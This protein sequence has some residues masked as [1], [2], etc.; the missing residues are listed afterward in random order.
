M[1][2]YHIDYKSNIDYWSDIANFQK[3]FNYLS[4]EKFTLIIEKT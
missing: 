3:I 2:F 1:N 4:D